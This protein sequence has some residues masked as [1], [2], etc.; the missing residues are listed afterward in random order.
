M[1]ETD[2]LVVGGGLVGLSAALFLAWRGVPTVLVERY[3]GSSAHPRA[4][5][6][7]ARTVELLRAVG[8]EPDIPP[9]LKGVSVR[10]VRAESLAGQWFEELHWS[11]EAPAPTVECSPCAGAGLAQDRMEPILRDK[12]R[13][14]GA[15]IRLSTELRSFEQDDDGVTAVVRGSDGAEY[16]VRAK[17]LVAADGHRSPVREELGIGRGGRGHLHTARSVLFRAPL[18][19][20]LEEGVGQFVTDVGFL[21]TYGDGRWVLMVDD[22]T[23]QDEET[24]RHVVNRAIGREDLDVEIITTGR[25]EVTAAIAD[26][27]R[28]DRIFLAGDAAHTLPPSRGGYGANTGIEDAHNLAWKLAAV[29]SGESGPAL[30][31]T[32]E[33]ERKP[34]AWLCHQQIFARS[35][36]HDPDG[37]V[38]DAPIIDDQ[39]MGFG[40]LYRSASVIGAGDDLP[41][42][43]RP[44]EWAGQPGT[45]APHL[46]LADGRSTLDLF[47]R[48][49]V[50]LAETA[51]WTGAAAEAGIRC[52]RVGD[53]FAETFGVTARGAS[54]IRPDGYVAWRSND[55]PADPV[56]ELTGVLRQVACA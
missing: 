54:L 18:Q 23:P 38:E 40:I 20:H 33:P 28:R 5:G 39:A 19:Q 4:I 51:E 13:E 44:D 34:V 48:G 29:L 49:W 3:P 9:P 14:L 21:T 47:Q 15:D 52:E 24:L 46:W 11:P 55:L 2:V 7:T 27:Y 8:L 31:D 53:R 25:W 6:Y 12:A 42:A 36:G 45:R 26:S 30:L 16:Q 10:R 41:P 17:Y 35:D 32:Y 1:R 37:P 43:R 22:S 50:L 56:A